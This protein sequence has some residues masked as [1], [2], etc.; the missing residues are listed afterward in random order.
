MDE[1]NSTGFRFVLQK[2]VAWAVQSRSRGQFAPGPCRVSGMRWHEDRPA[3]RLLGVVK[4]RGSHASPDDRAA[5]HQ[6]PDEAGAGIFNGNESHAEVDA[7]DVRIP[8][9]PV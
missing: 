9:V 1:W 3:L 2:A 8:P 4:A 7:D 5:S 6:S